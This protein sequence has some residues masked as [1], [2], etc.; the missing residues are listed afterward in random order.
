MPQA[1]NPQ[2]LNRY[3]YCLGNPLRYTDPTG[4]LAHE[5]IAQL[6]GFESVD[7]MYASDLWKAWTD[8]ETGDRYWIAVLEAIQSGDSLFASSAQGYLSFEKDGEIIRMFAHD[9][10]SPAL[11]LWQ[12]RG[13]Y[14]IDRPGASDEEMIA[15]RDQI[16]SENTDYSNL[17]GYAL[18]TQRL[19]LYA[20]E[21]GTTD[22][23]PASLTVTWAG[24]QIIERGI[25]P[26]VSGIC[27]LFSS[28][29]VPA[30]IDF[31]IDGILTLGGLT[32][33]PLAPYITG[34]GLVVCQVC[35]CEFRLRHP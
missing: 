20:W 7:K 13:I 26:Q 35:F 19:Y 29:E 16:F 23:S 30:W 28:G 31:G 5:E 18:Y 27:N 25:T 24:Y 4:H 6:L 33:G 2:A 3:S 8:E 10:A 34:F 32:T 1:G 17:V 21:S 11:V 12:G 15:L 14:T 9:G 22:Y